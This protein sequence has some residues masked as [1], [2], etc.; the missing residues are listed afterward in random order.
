MN[1]FRQFK[2]GAQ[3]TTPLAFRA[4]FHM[5]GFFIE[6]EELLTLNDDYV[7]PHILANELSL[8]SCERIDLLVDYGGAS[9]GIVELKNAELDISALGQLCRYLDKRD[10]FLD[11]YH[12]KYPSE[13]EEEDASEEPK[14]WVGVLVGESI[15]IDLLNALVK[16]NYSHNGT[17]IAVIELRRYRNELNGDVY[18]ITEVTSAPKNSRN[19]QKYTI[20]YNGHCIATSVGKSRM[21][22][23]VVRDYLNRHPTVTLAGLKQVFPDTVLNKGSQHL[24]E[25]FS[26]AQQIY[27]TTNRKRHRLD[28]SEVLTLNDGTEIVV[29]TQWDTGNINDFINLAKNLGYTI[30]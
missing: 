6:N 17:P 21:V 16:M 8:P 9:L 10:E 15:S 13:Q 11:A 29:S 27:N 1:V 20:S 14:D 3:E 19:Y 26:G 4:E 25:T 28:P 22:W 5:Q 23:E 2:V 12:S 30:I 18:S 7:N 24:I